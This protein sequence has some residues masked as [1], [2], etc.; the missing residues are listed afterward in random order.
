[1]VPMVELVAGRHTDPGVVDIAEA[2]YQRLGRVTVRVKKEVIGHLANWLTSA[3]YLE[4]VYIVAE[5]IADVEDID[6]AITYGPG[7]RWAFMGPHLTYHLGGHR[8]F[9]PQREWRYSLVG[10]VTRQLRNYVQFNALPPS[11]MPSLTTIFTT[12][13]TTL[14]IVSNCA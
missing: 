6:R 12:W 3:L 7:M 9:M 8:T 4:A 2:L 5:G 11:G 10:K 13:N 1:M 14:C